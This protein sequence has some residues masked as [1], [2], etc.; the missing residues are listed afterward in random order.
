MDPNE[1]LKLGPVTLRVTEPIPSLSVAILTTILGMA[2]PIVYT[3]EQRI[4]TFGLLNLMNTPWAQFS[5]FHSS[6]LKVAWKH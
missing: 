6:S 1:G 3:I 2:A 4:L 5:T